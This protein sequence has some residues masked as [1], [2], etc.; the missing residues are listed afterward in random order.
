MYSIQFQIIKYTVL[1]IANS[2]YL[3]FQWALEFLA[4]PTLS[5]Y[6]STANNSV[7]KSDY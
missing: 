3:E 2:T 5:F 4:K 7:T 6:K 1:F